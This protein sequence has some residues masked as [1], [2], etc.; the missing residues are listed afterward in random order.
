MPRIHFRGTLEVFDFETD[1]NIFVDYE[2]YYLT[3]KV[4][5]SHD[6][7]TPFEYEINFKHLPP[8]LSYMR[9]DLKE[10]VRMQEDF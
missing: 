8:H 1:N 4:G 9:E 6:T 2:G 5:K 3:A 10:R 7:C